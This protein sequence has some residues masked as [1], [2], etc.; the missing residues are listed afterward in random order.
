[1]FRPQDCWDVCCGWTEPAKAQHDCHMLF[2]T[3]LCE[4]PTQQGPVFD[5]QSFPF[6]VIC[7]PR[8]ARAHTK[9]AALT[10]GQ[11][12]RIVQCIKRLCSGQL[13]STRGLETPTRPYASFR[14]FVASIPLL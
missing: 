5:S 6:V 3:V 13:E 8:S 2:V 10:C 11:E 1:M 4:K 7:R 12:I 9:G 14:Y